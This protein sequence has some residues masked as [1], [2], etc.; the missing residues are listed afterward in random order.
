V[1]RATT[2]EYRGYRIVRFERPSKNRRFGNLKFWTSDPPLHPL[3]S[4]PIDRLLM[5]GDGTIYRQTRDEMRRVIDLHLDG[6]EPYESPYSPG[7]IYHH[8]CPGCPRKDIEPAS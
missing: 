6:P 1:K 8:E 4:D 2:E 3:T 7:K 5:R